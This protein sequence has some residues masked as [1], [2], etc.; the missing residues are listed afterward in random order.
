MYLNKS[1]AINLT[2]TPELK[3]LPSGIK[4][5]S[6][7]LATNRVWKD[8]NGAKQESSDFHNVVVFGSQAKSSASIL[9]RVVRLSLRDV[10][11]LEVGMRKTELKNT[12]LRS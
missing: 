1:I 6:L 7:S 11:R 8:K 2:Q 4:V 5:A 10:F 3:S 9:K 12:A